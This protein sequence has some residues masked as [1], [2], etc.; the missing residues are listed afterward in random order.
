MLTRIEPVP[1]GLRRNRHQ[2][3]SLATACGK[4]ASVPFDNLPRRFYADRPVRIRLAKN[5]PQRGDG[6]DVIRS[7]KKTF[8]P[9]SP[10]LDRQEETRCEREV[11]PFATR[12]PGAGR[13]KAMLACAIGY[14]HLNFR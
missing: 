9:R 14:N 11:A 3:T 5:K 6:R 1:V 7:Q 10:V 12:V 13:H 4:T 2:R 8:R